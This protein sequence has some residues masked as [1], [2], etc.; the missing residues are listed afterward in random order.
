MSSETSNHFSRVSSNRQSVVKNENNLW[1][2]TTANYNLNNNN[3]NNPSSVP[4]NS[5]NNINEK[6]FT[7]SLP[8]DNKQ[9]GPLGIHVIPAID[10]PSQR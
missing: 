1:S 3:I 7:I 9:P 2:S 6:V 8:V 5:N 10:P 4:I